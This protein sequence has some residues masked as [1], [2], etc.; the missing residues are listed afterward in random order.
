MLFL[1]L[2]IGFIVK[3]TKMA[4]QAMT[5]E[6]VLSNQ[7]FWSSQS[8][9][10]EGAFFGRLLPGWQIQYGHQTFTLKIKKTSDI[11]EI[12]PYSIIK[13]Q[14]KNAQ[15][16]IDS[17]HVDEAIITTIVPVQ[18]ESIKTSF[19]AKTARNWMQ[20]INSIKDFFSS[21]NFLDFRT[22][23]LVQSPGIEEHI[24]VFATTFQR[25]STQRALYLPTSPEFHLKK[26]LSLGW[27]QIFEIKDCFRNDEGSEIHQPE[28]T[29][30]EWYRAYSNL[31]AII[32]DTK[33]LLQH[34]SQKILQQKLEI[35]TKSIAN[36]FE[37]YLGFALQTTTSKSQLIQLL[38]SHSISYQN[39]D[40]WDDLYFRIFIEKIEPYL[41]K[42]KPLI[43]TKYPPSQAALARLTEDGWADRFELYWKGIELAN[44]F[45]E[46][47]DP[48]EQR[49]RFQITNEKRQM[50]NRQPLPVDDEFI[51]ALDFGLPPSGGIAL[52][53]E[54]LF[55]CFYNISDIAKVRAFPITS[56]D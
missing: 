35:E 30:L 4:Y 47:N 17:I 29:M 26:A 7:S 56:I 27:N 9:M 23:T 6:E 41:G 50:A 44:A 52:G 45:H 40:S 2:F 28:F 31:N 14:Y 1:A 22:P 32:E 46:L 49:R 19:D 39:T 18:N 34:L 15:K 13:L 16:F 24:D 21:Q 25:G 37:E 51:Q 33:N 8:I 12:S 11:E 5:N 43:V 38:K 3:L 10:K 48:Q 36:L 20:F 53:V 54:R 55:M 42:E